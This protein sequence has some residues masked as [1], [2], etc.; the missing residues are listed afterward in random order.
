MSVDSTRLTT[1]V[2]DVDGTLYRQGPL[3]RVMLLKLLGHVI[4]SPGAS[5]DTLRAL[6]AYRRAQEVLRSREVEGAIAAAQLRLASKDSGLPEQAVGTIVARWMDREPLARLEAL[7]QPALRTL[8]GT[9]RR[10][11]LRLG[12]LSDYPAAAKLDAMRLTEFFDVIITAQD[13]TVNRFKP[14]PAGLL[15]ALTRLGA[16]PNQALYVGDRDDVDGAAA[17]AAGVPC[18]IV[19]ER[20]VPN[21]A[22]STTVGDYEELHAMLFPTKSEQSS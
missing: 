20:R 21:V 6:R 19:G 4:S 7:V 8:L 13:A 5:V 22:G 14:H 17:R 15:Q 1:I 9:A 3:R 18:I 10:R 2:F 16:E 12:V 11:G